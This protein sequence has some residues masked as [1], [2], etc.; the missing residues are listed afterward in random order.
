MAAGPRLPPGGGAPAPRR[1]DSSRAVPLL[2][3]GAPAPRGAG[4]APSRCPG[5]GRD[6]TAPRAVR[7]RSQ[8]SLPIPHPSGGLRSAAGGP[9]AL[10]GR[11]LVIAGDGDAAPLVGARVTHI[12][13]RPVEEVRRDLAPYVSRDNPQG[14]EYLGTFFLQV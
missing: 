14:D 8:H 5:S 9:L 7:R 1:P 13:G 6:P 3:A 4:A 2:R 11:R 10:R 12:G